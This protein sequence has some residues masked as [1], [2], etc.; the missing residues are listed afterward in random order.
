MNDPFIA[1]LDGSNCDQYAWRNGVG[2]LATVLFPSLQPSPKHSFE[3][4]S[5]SSMEVR[6]QQV[7]RLAVRLV[8]WRGG[9]NR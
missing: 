4:Y 7:M 5:P 8:P 9:K 2:S 1:L 3:L 6:L